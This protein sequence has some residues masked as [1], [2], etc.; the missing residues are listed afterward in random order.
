MPD[1]H[2]FNHLFNLYTQNKATET[3]IAELF[4]LLKQLPEDD[5]FDPA[6]FALW[7]EINTEENIREPDWKQLYQ[8]VTAPVGVPK[9]KR[10]NYAWHYAAAA[11]FIGV[12]SAILFSVLHQPKPQET[13]ITYTV[14]YKTT[15]TLVFEDGSKAVLNA[16]TTL[17]YPK[18][19]GGKTRE[20]TLD[21][22]AF[23]QVVHLSNK[24][25]IVHSGKLQ[26][27][28]LGTSF[29]VDAYAKSASMKVTV[30]TGK[31]A[32]KEAS[33]GKQYMLTPNQQAVFSTT[34]A[35][36]KKVLI[37]DAENKIAWQ[38]G[39]L[40]FED[41]TLD[42]VASQLSLKFGVPTTLSNPQLK[43]CRI[44]AVFQHKQL[45]QI[46]EVVTKLTNSSYNLQSDK[47]VISG[48]GCN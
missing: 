46:L 24:P 27:Q 8:Q 36:F 28:V 17:K 6:F 21:G 18:H 11:V 25:F 38:D 23:F 20:I 45:S 30:V 32:V 35:S 48:K 40:I 9:I 2:R 29:N 37:A 33:T 39:K 16:G 31:V 42:E 47:A 41:A 3:Q 7:E 34:K 4:Q 44:S 15:K 26:T 14:P 22:E 12:F 19:F 5:R 1:N 43:N 10:F 13:Y